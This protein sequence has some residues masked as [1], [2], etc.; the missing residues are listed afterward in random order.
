M[1]KGLSVD[2]AIEFLAARITYLEILLSETVINFHANIESLM[3]A[4]VDASTLAKAGKDKVKVLI[5][6]VKDRAK[7]RAK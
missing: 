4:E 7:A 1:H 3:G 5:T 2:E 6:D